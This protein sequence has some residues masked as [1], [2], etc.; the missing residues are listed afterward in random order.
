MSVKD[1]TMHTKIEA[2]AEA[3]VLIDPSDLQALAG[4]HTQFGEIVRLAGEGTY[5][6]IVT[7]AANA[8]TD[9][10]EKIILNDLPDAAAGLRVVAGTVCALQEIIRDG[11]PAE[12]V[13]FPAELRLDAPKTD[14]AGT[15]S[16]PDA[17]ASS[18]AFV[19]PKALPCN[20][21]AKMFCDFLARQD[22]VLDEME[23][24][25]LSLEK[26]D[27]GDSLHALR[28]LLHTLKGEAAILG[29]DDVETLCH[30]TEDAIGL[31]SPDEWID[32]LLQVKDWLSQT[33][34]ACA[35]KSPAPQSVEQA[36]AI[37]PNHS[38]PVEKIPPSSAATPAAAREAP[39][40]A[41]PAKSVAP[42]VPFAG[43]ANSSQVDLALLQDFVCEA[44]EHLEAADIHLLTLETDPSS[45]EA[46]NAVFRAFHTIKGVAGCLG[47]DQ[48]RALAHEAENL[49]DKARKGELRLVGA[50][51][52]VAFDAV[53]ALRRLVAG[54]RQSLETGKAVPSD[55]SISPLLSRIAAA[56]SGQHLP[57]EN[58]VAA[59][60]PASPRAAPRKL[61][62]IL[63]D[64]GAVTPDVVADAVSR[65]GKQGKS[66]LGEILVHEGKVHAKVVAH[67]L[68]AQAAES[69]QQV[70]A[71]EPGSASPSAQASGSVQVKEVVKIDAE[72]LD[73]LLDTIGELV[74]AESMISQSP[75]LRRQASPDL[76]RQLTQLDKITR[77]LQETGTSLRMV[78][79][80][81]T[82]QKMARLVRDLAKKFGKHIDF[83][84]AGDDTELD[85]AV[86]DRIGDPLVHMVR[87]SV[88]HG[89]EASVEERRAAGKPDAGRV[90]LR[91]FHRG[92]SIYIQIIDDGRGLNRQ[93]ILSKAIERGLVAADAS[94]TDQEVWNLIFAPGLSTAKTVTDVSGRG[95]GMDVVKR[96]IEQ[97]H[98]QIEIQSTP[99]K[100]TIFSIKLPLTLAI[101]DGMVI[102]VADRRYVIPTLSIVRSVRPQSTDLTTVLGR[103]EMLD[104]QGKLLPLFRLGRLFNISGAQEDPTQAIVTI[105]EDEGRQVGLLIDDLLG[106]QQIVIK[107]LGEA[108]QGVSGLSGGAIMPDGTVGLIL[109]VSG[110]VKLAHSGSGDD[111][112]LQQNQA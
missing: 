29:L 92:G 62:E 26:A 72:R 84:T 101:I 14:P 36:L 68:R 31:R 53:D 66:R 106:Q 21:D 76:M 2:L 107:S 82:F 42:G 24:M 45:A 44:G 104:I 64:S 6:P 99:G 1:N 96:N 60:E 9:V 59:P 112:S 40:I 47:L 33:F 49:L 63:V 81:A 51:I 27:S 58:T 111:A 67:A 35:G 10:L 7:T 12:Q 83:V 93:A 85:K 15:Q 97:L 17:P 3:I 22:A 4:L 78:P 8:A 25:I 16:S 87:N 13:S 88:D 79:I 41:A 80:R 65:Q 57:C 30:A 61:G 105:V 23:G 74:I 38:A 34:H 18:E 5:P 37:L 39:P 28:R 50:P 90:E 20:V 110:L 11:R 98:G 100:G 109:D 102:R 55:D 75:E 77:G 54:V 95:V 91:A 69:P 73:R 48:I 108:M 70:P 94:P 46:I 19:H 52:D 43:P 71:S 56:A 103:G 86:V 89:L 32:G